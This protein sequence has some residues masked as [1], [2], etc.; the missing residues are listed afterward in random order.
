M[1]IAFNILSPYENIWKHITKYTLG[2]INIF[3]EITPEKNRFM[4]D[5]L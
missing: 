3:S 2:S 5:T 1:I 4:S